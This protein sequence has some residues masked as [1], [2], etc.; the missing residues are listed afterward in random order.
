VS[1]FD[2]G[3]VLGQITPTEMVSAAQ[4]A[5]SDYERYQ[6]NALRAGA[7]VREEHDASRLLRV[8]TE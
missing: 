7:A 1:R 3:I 2:A 4:K 8:L 5:K 6:S